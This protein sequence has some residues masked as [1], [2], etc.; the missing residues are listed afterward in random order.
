MLL[1]TSAINLGG[2]CVLVD[3]RRNLTATAE[4]LSTLIQ[5]YIW[6]IV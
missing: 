2:S 4:K 6:L 1:G 5:K 3:Y